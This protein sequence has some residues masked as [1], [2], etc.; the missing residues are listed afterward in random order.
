MDEYG[1]VEELFGDL[2]D[3]VAL[4]APVSRGRL[5]AALAR[6]D[7]HGPPADS[8]ATVRDGLA[9]HRLPVD[10]WNAVAAACGLT[11]AAEVAAREVHRR[12]AAALGV[13]ADP[14]EAVFVRRA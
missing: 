11:P 13:A 2:I 7:A 1:A 6:A 5:V 14:T 9:V 3:E 10:G 8:A 4:E 12:L